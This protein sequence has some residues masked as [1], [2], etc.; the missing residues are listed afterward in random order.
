MK[1][2]YVMSQ[3]FTQFCNQGLYSLS[4]DIQVGG[5]DTP[6]DN[7]EVLCSYRYLYKGEHNRNMSSQQAP[8][9]RLRET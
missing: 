3:R 7:S 9:I 4:C 8:I 5:S 2:H 1:Y 6:Q